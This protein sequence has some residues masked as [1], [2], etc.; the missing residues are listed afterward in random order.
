MSTFALRPRR[1]LACGV[2]SEREVAVSLNGERRPDLRAAILDG[3]FQ[4]YPCP[5]CGAPCRVQDPFVYLHFAR[6]EWIT[7]FSPEREPDWARLECEPMEDWREGMVTFAPPLVR[8]LSAGF[9]VRAVF[10]VDALREKLLC[11]EHG[12]DDAWL[13]LLKLQLHRERADL[14]FSP[15]Q[16]LRLY[17]VESD[18]LWFGVTGANR[19]LGVAREAL[20]AL[21]ED[22]IA[23]LTPM[24]HLTRGPYVDL[25]RIMF[26]PESAPQEQATA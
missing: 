12:L 13:E 19:T 15:R 6:K 18:T 5:S 25:G 21:Q 17:A 8:D 10:G 11:F 23:W 9:R 14:T 22:P 24:E 3:S 16:R 7:C 20:L 2:S 26:A 1:C 4:R